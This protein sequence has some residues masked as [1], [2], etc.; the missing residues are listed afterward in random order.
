MPGTKLHRSSKKLRTRAPDLCTKLS[1]AQRLFFL[2][3]QQSQFQVLATE[4]FVDTGVD[5]WFNSQERTNKAL[6]T[7]P[8]DNTCE[9]DEV[10]PEVEAGVVSGLKCLKP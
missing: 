10:S 1:F 7:G 8:L 2:S 3:S 9:A 4:P 6:N 5:S